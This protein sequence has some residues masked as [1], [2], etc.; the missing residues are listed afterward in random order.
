[1]VVQC[2]K[3]NESCLHFV[4]L[5]IYIFRILRKRSGNQLLTEITCSE[6]R[7]TWGGVWNY[8]PPKWTRST[9]DAQYPSVPLPLWAPVT[10]LIPS[11][12][13][14]FSDLYCCGTSS[15]MTHATS[16]WG[17]HISTV[18]QKWS[19]TCSKKKSD[20]RRNIKFGKMSKFH[21]LSEIQWP[22][23]GWR[24]KGCR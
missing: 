7:G 2:P 14:Q 6:N 18:L 22:L 8:C 12:V 24:K 15:S 20:G 4:Q 17:W 23:A 5:F 1:M 16:L 10:A 19:K 9:K 21:M 11:Q 13:G 3:C